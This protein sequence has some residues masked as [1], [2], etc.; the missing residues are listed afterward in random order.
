MADSLG[1]L[2]TSDRHFDPVVNLTAA[3]HKKGKSD[4]DLLYRRGR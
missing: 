4:S 2:V 3:A 1:I